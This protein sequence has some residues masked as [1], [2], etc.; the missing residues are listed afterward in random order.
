MSGADQQTISR[1]LGYLHYI[2]LEGSHNAFAA[3]CAA[4][5]GHHGWLLLGQPATGI[6]PVFA[7]AAIT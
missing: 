5:T 2:F 6:A 3:Q 4:L 1:F 7:L